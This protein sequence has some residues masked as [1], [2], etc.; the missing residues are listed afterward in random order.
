MFDK[1][2][3]INH[4]AVVKKLQEIMAA[5]GKKRTNRKEQ[6]ELLT[7][8]LG[9][10][11]EHELGIAIY[12]KVQFAIISA[13]YDYNPKISAAMKPEYW[14]KCMPAVEKLLTWLHDNAQDLTTGD[15]V[16][17]RLVHQVVITCT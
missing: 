8:L 3:E 1:D 2:A 9:I 17:E 5:R 15:Q 6:I 16:S 7:E 13:V 12:A 10:S 11:E 14:E 4:E